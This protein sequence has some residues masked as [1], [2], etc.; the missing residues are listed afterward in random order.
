MIEKI[1]ILN[2]DVYEDGSTYDNE[3]IYYFTYDSDGRVTSYYTEDSEDG[4]YR[5]TYENNTIVI[6]FEGEGNYTERSTFT[7]GEDGYVTN[8]TSVE[9]DR[10][11]TTGT[12]TYADGYVREGRLTTSES[13]EERIDRAVWENGNLVK[14][15]SL[16]PYMDNT[17]A[18]IS[19]DNP[20][21]VN[22]PKINLDL[23]YLIGHSE[24]L[25]CFMFGG[26]YLQPF[27]YIGQRSALYMTEERD[28]YDGSYYTYTYQFDE[29]GRPVEI[30]KV[31]HTNDPYY[32]SEEYTYTITYKE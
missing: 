12:L 13:D 15:E 8:F 6:D 4:I 22:N 28:L 25:E 9:N 14:V 21:Y 3:D 10:F 1:N 17:A 26:L 32:V 16:I 18:E 24:W 11:T 31:C 29:L 7:L 5:V 2:H 30:H 19:Y 20:N 27:G 23:N